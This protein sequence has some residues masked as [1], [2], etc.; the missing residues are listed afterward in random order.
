LIIPVAILDF[1]SLSVSG[2]PVSGDPV[3]LDGIAS[4]CSFINCLNV[5]NFLSIIYISNYL[6]LFINR[7]NMTAIKE[8]IPD[9]IKEY[10]K[11]S[12][13]IL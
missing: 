8:T 10:N 11:K 1:A 5:N 7:D 3:A 12:G 6:D 13:L 2:F 4:S 9:P